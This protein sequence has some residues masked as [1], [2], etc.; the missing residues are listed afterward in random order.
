MEPRAWLSSAHEEVGHHLSP[1]RPNLPMV[2]ARG[3]AGSPRLGTKSLRDNPPV[4]EVVMGGQPRPEMM[5]RYW[6]AALRQI[7]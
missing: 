6:A 7:P 5:K 2:V 1:R 4:A 3:K